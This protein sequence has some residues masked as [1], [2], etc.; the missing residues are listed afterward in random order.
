MSFKQFTTNTILK[1]FRIFDI[2]PWKIHCGLYKEQR[3]KN[4]F[5]ILY[6]KY[7]LLTSLPSMISSFSRISLSSKA[8]NPTYTYGTWKVNMP[9]TNYES[10]F[11]N[12]P[13]K[14]I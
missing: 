5:T 7:I 6:R 12:N 1:H 9:M 3:L 13:Y 8:G 2:L 4:R 14:K 11:F 10:L